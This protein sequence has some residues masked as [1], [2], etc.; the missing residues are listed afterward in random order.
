MPVCDS[1]V[2]L[3]FYV[4]FSPTQAHVTQLLPQYGYIHFNTKTT[5]K[6]HNLEFASSEYAHAQWHNC[7]DTVQAQENTDW[8]KKIQQNVCL[9]CPKQRD[10]IWEQ[11]EFSIR[12]D[13]QE[14][15]PLNKNSV[16]LAGLLEYQLCPTAIC[17]S[18]CVVLL[19]FLLWVILLC[20][21]VRN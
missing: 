3:S 7:M 4:C 18:S 5:N 17:K 11:Q 6:V 10:R 19:H 20:N 12:L 1:F 14:I 9:G 21:T 8:N 16:H 15:F 13:I 2:W